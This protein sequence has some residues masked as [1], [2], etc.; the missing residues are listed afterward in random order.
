VRGQRL[1]QVHRVRRRHVEAGQ[2]HVDDDRQPEVVGWI[3]EPFRQ[4]RSL[5]LG[6][7]VG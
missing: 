7:D 3:L 6:A 5:R 4:P 2:P 1:V